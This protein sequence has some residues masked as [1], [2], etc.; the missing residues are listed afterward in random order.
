MRGMAN[1]CTLTLDC[2]FPPHAADAHPCGHPVRV[3]DPCRFCGDPTVA[4]ADGRPIPCP[5]C[6][7]ALD[8]L[9]LADIKGL[10]ALGDL[11]VE[12]PSREAS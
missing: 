7:I 2:G 9:P 8:G 5:K 4:D 6:W 11:S 3:G 12:A 1:R 10:L